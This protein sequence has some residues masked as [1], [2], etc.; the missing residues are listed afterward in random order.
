MLKCQCS[1][2]VE[3]TRSTAI[4]ESRYASSH[5][6]CADTF[7][8]HRP[9]SGFPLLFSSLR[10][11]PDQSVRSNGHSDSY[12]IRSFPTRYSHLFCYTWSSTLPTSPNQWCR[13]KW[14]A[15]I[16]SPC[17]CRLMN[18]QL[19][20]GIRTMPH[21]NVGNRSLQESIKT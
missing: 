16:G 14:L 12:L 18:V 13:L 2:E 6:T 8:F 4:A 17:R 5:D 19:T 21:Q 10:A 3:V 11:R 9:F 20:F 1:A 15:C 7:P